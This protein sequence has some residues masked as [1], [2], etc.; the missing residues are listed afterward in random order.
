MRSIYCS[1]R[2][3]DDAVSEVEAYHGTWKQT[4]VGADLK[5]G[6]PETTHIINNTLNMYNYNAELTY[7]RLKQ[8]VMLTVKLRK[9][10]NRSIV[11]RGPFY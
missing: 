2:I 7:M 4:S 1:N 6:T 3:N 5:N 8:T 10:A 11:N 9:Y